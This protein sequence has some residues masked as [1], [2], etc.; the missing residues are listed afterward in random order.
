MTVHG[1]ARARTVA[2]RAQRTRAHTVRYGV[3][4]MSP[5]DIEMPPSFCFQSLRPPT[6][7][8]VRVVG[9]ALGASQPHDGGH[10]HEDDLARA[11]AVEDRLPLGGIRGGARRDARGSLLTASAISRSSWAVAVFGMV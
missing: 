8:L 1:D 2:C 5:W 4:A 7:T 6:R 10:R 9:V 3:T 11:E